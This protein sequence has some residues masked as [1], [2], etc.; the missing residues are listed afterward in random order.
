MAGAQALTRKHT[1]THLYCI[2][3]PVQRAVFAVGERNDN[4]SERRLR[5]SLLPVGVELELRRVVDV[6]GHLGMG[7]CK[8]ICA[9]CLHARTLLFTQ[10]VTRLGDEG[11]AQLL[12]SD[13]WGYKDEVGTRWARRGGSR[14]RSG[15][16]SSLRACVSGAQCER[17]G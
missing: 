4:A 16:G 12:P 15:L 10:Q 2:T 1:Q 7:R 14:G 11:F 17:A 6:E 3:E 9:P 13:E 8:R 5:F